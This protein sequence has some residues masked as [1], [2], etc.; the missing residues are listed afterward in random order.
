MPEL[1]NITLTISDQVVK[2]IFTT[3]VNSGGSA[4]WANDYQDLYEAND[5]QGCTTEFR[6][7]APHEDAECNEP[8]VNGV[9]TLADML[10]ALQTLIDNRGKRG[11]VN[12]RMVA[13]LI[14]S[15]D[16]DGCGCDAFEADAVLQVAVFGSVIY[17]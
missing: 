11:F 7:G 9:I 6:I 12:E 3:A 14:K 15:M 2:D 5:D 10:K 16:D 8:V 1:V 13:S 17:G 4:Y